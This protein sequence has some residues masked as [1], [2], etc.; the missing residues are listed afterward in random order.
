MRDVYVIG[1]HTTKFG[2]YLEKSIKDLS[3][4]TVIPCLKMGIC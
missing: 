4:E 3:A 1:A 2:R